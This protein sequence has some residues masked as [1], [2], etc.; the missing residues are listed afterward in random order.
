MGGESLG[1]QVRISA[2]VC[3]CGLLPVGRSAWGSRCSSPS[4]REKSVQWMEMHTFP[5]LTVPDQG[6]CLPLVC[7]A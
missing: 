4:T 1:M 6:V 2:L 3:L 5:W 7:S